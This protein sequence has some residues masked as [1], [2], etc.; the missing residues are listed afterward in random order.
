[1][2]QKL[3]KLKRDLNHFKYIATPGFNTLATNVFNARLAQA[4]LVTKTDFDAKLSNLNREITK[5]ESEL[6]KLKTFDSSYRKGKSNFEEDGMQNCLV[7][8]PMYQYIKRNW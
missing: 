3:L 8:Q 6:K 7:F 1:M 2:I 5:N 4:N